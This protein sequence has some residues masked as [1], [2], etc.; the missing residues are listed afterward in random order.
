MDGVQRLFNEDLA[1]E[2]LD[3]VEAIQ[4]RQYPSLDWGDPGAR[5]RAR[6]SCSARRP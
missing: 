4:R 3:L 2:E 5:P 6:C 1:R